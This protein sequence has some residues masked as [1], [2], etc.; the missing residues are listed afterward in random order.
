MDSAIWV[1]AAAHQAL[2][3][4]CRAKGSNFQSLSLTFGGSYGD[5]Q[6]VMY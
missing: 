4:D 6:W 1:I 5:D 3:F 2:P